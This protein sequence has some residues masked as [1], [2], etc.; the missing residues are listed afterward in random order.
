MIYTKIEYNYN[1]LYNAC[2]RPR[3][4]RGARRPVRRHSHRGL[5]RDLCECDNCGVVVVVVVA[6]EV[7]VI[8]VGVFV[9]VITVGSLSLS[10]SL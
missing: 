1:R 7:I 8:L 2:I 3:S 10:L 6:V 5:G 4:T 9:N